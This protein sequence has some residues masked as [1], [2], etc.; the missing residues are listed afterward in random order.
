MT[1]DHQFAEGRGRHALGR[2][3]PPLG[4]GRVHRH[5]AARPGRLRAPG[6]VRTRH[7]CAAPWSTADHRCRSRHGRA[8]A[9]RSL[10]RIATSAGRRQRQDGL[11]TTG[12]GLSI[13]AKCS[14]AWGAE[15]AQNRKIVWFEPA[16]EVRPHVEPA[17][18]LDC[19][20]RAAGCPTT[21]TYSSPVTILGANARTCYALLKHYRELRRELR[22]L[23]LTHPD[24]YPL[25]KRLSDLIFA[26]EAEFPKAAVRPVGGRPARRPGRTRHLG[27]SLVQAARADSSDAGTAGSGRRLLP[28]TTVLG[29]GPHAGPERLLPLVPR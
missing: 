10:R 28:R 7:Q 18:S 8:S 12:R 25:A 15:V 23:A 26:F 22:L 13:V 24:D 3:R 9:D 20:C 2:A 11:A 21:T 6:S 17:Y 5:R 19:R 1:L 27:R 16:T 29:T 14:I 4:R